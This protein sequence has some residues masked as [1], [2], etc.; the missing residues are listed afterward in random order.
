MAEKESKMYVSFLFFFFVFPSSFLCRR[1]ESTALKDE[2][3]RVLNQYV[4]EIIERE[5]LNACIL[6]RRKNFTLQCR[7]SFFILEKRRFFLRCDSWEKNMCIKVKLSMHNTGCKIISYSGK[8]DLWL[9]LLDDVTAIKYSVDIECRPHAEL[10]MW[11]I[12]V[13]R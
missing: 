3:W 6:S 13:C 8:L 4:Y 11:F 1:T 5:W 7:P 12:C 9:I 2:I 10:D